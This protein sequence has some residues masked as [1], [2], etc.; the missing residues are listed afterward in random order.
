MKNTKLNCPF[1]GSYRGPHYTRIARLWSDILKAPV[2]PPQVALCLM[3]MH[4]S[5]LLD[6]PEQ[7]QKPMDISSSAFAY[8]ILMNCDDKKAA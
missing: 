5:D 4:V 6:N 1:G 8:E 7:S 3:Q 2:T